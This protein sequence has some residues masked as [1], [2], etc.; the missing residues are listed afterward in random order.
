MIMTGIELGSLIKKHIQLPL[1]HTNLRTFAN[2][3]YVRKRI[4]VSFEDAKE[5]FMF[6]RKYLRID[7]VNP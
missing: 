3:I 6:S 4:S 5:A 2:D 1:Q 7:E